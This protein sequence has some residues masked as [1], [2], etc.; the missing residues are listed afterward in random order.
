MECIQWDEVDAQLRRIG[1]QSKFR[2]AS[3]NKV[4]KALAMN[5]FTSISWRISAPEAIC[6]GTCGV[7]SSGK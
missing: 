3:R 5:G 6:T 1:V 4:V 2:V 7:R